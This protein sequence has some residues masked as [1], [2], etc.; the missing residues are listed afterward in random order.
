MGQSV[1]VDV[2]CLNLDSLCTWHTCSCQIDYNQCPNATSVEQVHLPLMRR[3]FAAED[4]WQAFW[5]T[6]EVSPSLSETTE[7][8][9]TATTKGMDPL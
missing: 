5:H 2:S 9:C 1:V 8:S 6:E 3:G 7:P 4:A